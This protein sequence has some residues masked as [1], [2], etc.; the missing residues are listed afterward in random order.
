ML[1]FSRRVSSKPSGNIQSIHPV[2]N[3][4]RPQHKTHSRIESKS[5]L[6][7]IC[8]E[9]VEQDGTAH[10]HFYLFVCLFVFLRVY[11]EM[12]CKSAKALPTL[13]MLL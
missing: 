9:V 5:D 10:D 13:Y 3:E 6:T 2:I 12:L 8:D 7:Q 11:L 1:A 4:S